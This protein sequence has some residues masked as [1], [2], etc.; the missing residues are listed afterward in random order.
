MEPQTYAQLAA[1]ED[2]HW[3]H[4]SR[5]KLAAY[6]I[7]RMALPPDAAILDVGCGTGGTTRFLQQFGRVTG[8]DLSPLAVQ[9]ARA[10]APQATIVE[11]DANELNR[12][13]A[14]TSFD[15]V[16]LFNVLY[17]RWV[18]DDADMLRQIHAL[19]KPGGW[20]LVTDA[21]HRSLMREHDVLDMGK[22]RYTL[23]DFRRY[24]GETGFR[25]VHGQYFN[26]PALPICLMLAL[27][28]RW[29]GSRTPR[30]N[31]QIAELNVPPAIINRAM[32]LYMSVENWLF[33]RLPLSVGVTLLVVGRKH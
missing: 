5:E 23:A 3:W 32:L 7:R 33:G 29:F 27:K 30:S 25:Y 17:H 26:A 31:E 14:P 22:T 24:F 4:R 13:F 8:V 12:L 9:H 21:A 18:R 19:L 16:T 28:H 2:R 1:V 10:K 11:G 6:Y 20:L 15:L